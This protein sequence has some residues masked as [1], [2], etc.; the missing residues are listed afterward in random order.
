MDIACI[1]L[2]AALIASAVYLWIEGERDEFTARFSCK[3][4]GRES[5][6]SFPTKTRIDRA[7]LAGN[8]TA[9]ISNGSGPEEIF[10]DRCKIGSLF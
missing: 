5:T 6:R 10:C 8:S 3:N 2:V 1:V 9:T 4:C 7:N